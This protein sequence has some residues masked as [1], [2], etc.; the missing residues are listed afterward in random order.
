M[1]NYGQ[2]GSFLGFTYNN[3]HSSTLGITRVSSSNRQ[4]DNLIP[5]T[6]EVAT[7]IVGATGKVYFGTTY[8]KR[9]I[10][11]S[12]AFEGLTEEQLRQMH[13]LWDGK[14]IH[15]LIFDEYPYKIYSAKI[16]GNATIKHLMFDDP[17]QGIIYKGEGTIKFTCYFPF[18]RSRYNWQE[19]YNMF[20]IP[21]W[22][23]DENMIDTNCGNIYYDWDVT[24]LAYGGLK[25]EQNQF[26]WVSPQSLLL[27]SQDNEHDITEN[28][29]II[30]T[31]YAESPFI[32]YDEWIASS[33]IPSR[34][35]YG[36][37]DD[38]A[39]CITLFN[40]GD[41]EMPTQWWFL[42]PSAPTNYTIQCSDKQLVITGLQKS[43][44]PSPN[45]AGEDKYIVI[46]MPNY[47][48]EGYNKYKEPTGR[49]Y[50]PCISN[51]TFFGIPLGEQ[52]INCSQEPIEIKFNY[53]Y[54]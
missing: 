5:T 45:K 2:R 32:N 6:K 19:E 28:G 46:D 1:S 41:I 26:T 16:T 38:G 54:L 51:G 34:E 18:A 53:L 23:N 43:N 37:Y 22:H 12:F 39:H 25:G 27:N 52:V 17:D 30:L 9:D 20:T 8:A 50:N 3:I 47:S 4:N 33:R 49:V 24:Q 36:I 31:E 44:V 13:V 10:S 11:V 7:D 48:I 15:D 14:N 40:A 35:D 29:K 21:E 42:A